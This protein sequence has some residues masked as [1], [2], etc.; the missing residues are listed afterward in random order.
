MTRLVFYKDHSCQDHGEKPAEKHELWEGDSTGG[1]H[2]NPGRK[3]RSSEDLNVYNRRK[4]QGPEDFSRWAPPE[5]TG[6]EAPRIT[7]RIPLG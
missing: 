3:H 1:H 2:P 4:G 6:R 5:L 7:P